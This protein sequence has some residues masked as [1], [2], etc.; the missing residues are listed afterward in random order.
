MRAVHGSPRSGNPA[1]GDDIG[2]SS[3]AYGVSWRARAEETDCPAPYGAA[4]QLPGSPVPASVAGLGLRP[5]PNKRRARDASPRAHVLVTVLRYS[6]SE[7]DVRPD[8]KHLIR[9]NLEERR[10]AER[11]A[12]HEGEQ[13]LPPHRHSRPIRSNQRFPAQKERRP[14]EVD[15]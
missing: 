13:A 7:L 2:L 9:R 4:P 8:F 12:R 3:E 5:L 15:T 1:V 14:L 11:I 10:R 6:V